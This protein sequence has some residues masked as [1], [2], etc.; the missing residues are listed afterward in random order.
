MSITVTVAVQLAVAPLLSVT[1][2]VTELSPVLA[3]E[4]VFG[5]TLREAIPAVAVEPLLTCEALNVTLPL[6]FR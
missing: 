5:L 4:N 2:S 3:Q 1:V 6:L